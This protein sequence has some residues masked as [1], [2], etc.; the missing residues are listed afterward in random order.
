[1]IKISL[2]KKNPHSRDS[3]EGKIEERKPMF[4]FRFPQWFIDKYPSKV[5]TFRVNA[6]E[7]LITPFDI[8]ATLHHLLDINREKYE[9][10]HFKNEKVDRRTKLTDLLQI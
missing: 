4:G 5:A 6:K 2:H 8:H 7:R 3:E 10:G 9:I 1:M